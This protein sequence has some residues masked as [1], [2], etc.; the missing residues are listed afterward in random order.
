MAVGAGRVIAR[1]KELQLEAGRAEGVGMVPRFVGVGHPL[2]VRAGQLAGETRWALAIVAVT[3]T[4]QALATAVGMGWRLAGRGPALATA[5]GRAPLLAARLQEPVT[6]E[7][8]GLLLAGRTAAQVTAAGATA[9]APGR[10]LPPGG[11]RLGALGTAAV[12]KPALAVLQG[13]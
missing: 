10:A 11:C 4:A 2:E 5:V 1:V 12:R 7:A 13:T 3:G 9:L 6:A 8:L